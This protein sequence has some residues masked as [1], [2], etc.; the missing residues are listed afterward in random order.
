MIQVIDVDVKDS[1]SSL[2]FKTSLNK[3]VCVF[4]SKLAEKLRQIL[5]IV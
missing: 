5:L 2:I 1:C 3:F 4:L